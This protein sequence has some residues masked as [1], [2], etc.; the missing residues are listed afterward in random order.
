MEVK[1]YNELVNDRELNE[2]FLMTCAELIN[3]I[4]RKAEE[5]KVN[6]LYSWLNQV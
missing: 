2:D 4:F 5:G 6:D 3:K 1:E